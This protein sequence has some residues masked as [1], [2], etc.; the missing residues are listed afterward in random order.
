ML[1]T[2]LGISTL[3]FGVF[4]MNLGFGL[5]AT[6]LGVRAGM[7]GFPVTFTGFIMAMY[8]TGYAVGSLF[9]PRLVQGVGHIRTFAALASLASA[10][11]LLHAL[12][13][14]PWTWVALRGVT[15]LCLA[16]LIIV[17]ESWLNH[18]ATNRDR[19]GVLS[20]YMV[21][22]LGATALGQLLLNAA[23]VEGAELFILVSV[24]VS[25]S[26][27]PM[28][29]STKSVPPLKPTRTMAVARIFRLSPMGAVG[30][31]STGL[32]NG[33]FWGMG[34]L[35]ALGAGLDARGISLFMAVAVLGGMVSQWPVGRLSDRIDRRLVIAALAAAITAA[36]LGLAVAGGQSAAA[37]LALGALFGVAAFPLYAIS[38]A[39]VNDVMAPEEFVPASSALLRIYAIGAAIGPFA[40]G[41]AMD[42]VG[43]AGL[44]YYAAAISALL[45]A[46]SLH[47]L[48]KGNA[49]HA[50][51]KEEFAAVPHTSPEVLKM[52]EP[53]PPR[54]D[55]E[56]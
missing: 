33:A 51:H 18:A 22:S 34:A 32:I 13:V 25:V 44:F 11:A 42:A 7:E 31:L 17:S 36:S 8:Y 40:A 41:Y 12:F 2:L 30:C 16:G 27:V 47:R 55:A 3:L 9:S 5:Q 35:Y 39:H 52:V 50:D 46:F 38:I 15:G 14:T 24:L 37:M 54:T 4:A 20:A 1:G 19:G 45:G 6:L 43:A 10:A 28:A 29:L 48:R 23:P 26:L 21:V 56:R 49:I 53:A